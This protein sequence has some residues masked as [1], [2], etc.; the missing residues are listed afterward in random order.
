MSIE[1]ECLED[2]ARVLDK[3]SGRCRSMADS[4]GP[5]N[6]VKILDLRA[7]FEKVAVRV[8]G[9]FQF[10]Q[11]VYAMQMTAKAATRYEPP[12]DNGEQSIP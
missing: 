5:L 1:R 8:V 11:N 2:M 6:P 3:L 7:E 9:R 4:E 10:L 12:R